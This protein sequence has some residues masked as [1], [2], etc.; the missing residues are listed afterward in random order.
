MMTNEKRIEVSRVVQAPPDR[1]FALVADPEQHHAIDGSGHL[2]GTSNGPITGVGKV[3][4]MEMYRDDLGPWRTFNTVTEYE[5]DTA[6]G[7][8]PDLDPDCPLA[9]KLAGITTGG[10]TYTYRLRETGEGTEVRLSYDWSGVTDPNF[11]AFCPFVSQEQLAATLDR[12]AETA[13]P[14]AAR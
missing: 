7:W 11:E 8:A 6:L 2:R 10:H 1:V 14:A 12:L 9:P 5:P 13:Q 3:F 4:T